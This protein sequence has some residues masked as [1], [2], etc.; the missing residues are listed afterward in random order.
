M[1]EIIFSV[2]ILIVILMSCWCSFY[3][4]Y[5]NSLIK[6]STYCSPVLNIFLMSMSLLILGVGLILDYDDINLP[7]Y[8]LIVIYQILYL[9]S[10]YNFKFESAKLFISC[11]YIT[12][13][14]FMLSGT[15][16]YFLIFPYLVYLF[17]E[18]CLTSNVEKYNS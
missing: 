14:I 1:K 13:I 17:Y 6:D 5:Y 11:S 15:K 9:Y 10:F 18:F 2:L 4:N 7:F 3:I 12:T 16:N 8:L